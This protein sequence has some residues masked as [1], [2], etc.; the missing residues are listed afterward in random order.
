MGRPQGAAEHHAEREELVGG[1][2]R[3]ARNRRTRATASRRRATRAARPTR[4]PRA[5]DR[6]GKE[7]PMPHV[8]DSISLLACHAGGR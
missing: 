3:E 5:E 4:P 1:F 8:A 2:G 6:Q 7:P